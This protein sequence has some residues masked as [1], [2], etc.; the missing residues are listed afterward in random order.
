MSWPSRRKLLTLAVRGI[1]L[2]GT[3]LFSSARAVA[4]PRW[5]SEYQVGALYCHADFPLPRHEGLWR[6]IAELGHQ[7]SSRL[8]VPPPQEP[9]HL[10][11]FSQ[12]A[13]YRDYLRQHFP[14][15]PY[16]RALFLKRSGPGMVFAHLSHDFPTDVRHES[17]HALLHASLPLVPLWL[18]EGLA[19]YFEVP[20]AE[21][22][23]GNPHLGRIRWGARFGQV[24]RL[25]ELEALGE[26]DAMDAAAYRHAW[27]WAHFLLHGPAEAH[28]EL[29]SFLGDIQ[30]HQPPGMLSQRLRRRIPEL[31]QRY[32]QHFRQWK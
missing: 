10:F 31:E 1:L 20:A 27:A 24:P 3:Q 18:D 29:V 2:G 12:E 23:S 15:V 7:L 13:T 5:P 25:E 14:E 21:R 16:R 17:T 28:D 26:L 11:L 30:R 6:E 8:R 19:E 32:L 22:A 9:I 4:E